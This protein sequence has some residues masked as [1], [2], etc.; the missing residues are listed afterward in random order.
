MGTNFST[1]I[2]KEGVSL[3]CKNPLD[4]SS[5]W[6]GKDPETGEEVSIESEVVQDDMGRIGAEL[7][8]LQMSKLFQ[9][10]LQWRLKYNVRFFSEGTLEDYEAFLEK[11]SLI[12]HQNHFHMVTAKHSLCQMLGR[13]ECCLIQDM[14][15]ELVRFSL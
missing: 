4:Q 1:V 12:L 5:P 8:M 10:T 9:V 6:V 2:G 11:Y 13:T 3:T 15:I 7:A 14:P